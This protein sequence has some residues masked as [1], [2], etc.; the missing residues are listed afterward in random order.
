MTNYYTQ[1]DTLTTAM[2]LDYQYY[3]KSVKNSDL[4]VLA[5]TG[6]AGKLHLQAGKFLYHSGLRNASKIVIYDKSR[7]KTLG[8]F[9][10][11]FV[12]FDA[13]F[14][15]VKEEISEIPHKYLVCVGTSGGGHSAMLYAH[16]LNA[17]SAVVFSTYPY[18][19]KETIRAM[20]DPAAKMMA[21]QIELFDQLP[22]QAKKY[23]DLDKVLATW[24]G[25]TRYSMHASANHKW[26]AKRTLYMQRVPGVEIKLHPYDAHGLGGVLARSGKLRECFVQAGV[27]VGN[28]DIHPDA[29][30]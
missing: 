20:H 2:A 15:F 12:D 7:L 18:L 25:T 5:F 17:D 19:K 22:M 23:F 24:N 10:P 11:R 6:W 16:L 8:G 21:D 30:E 14:Q 9:P 4:L 3:Q 1:I 13:C 27:P 26:D 29:M 28:Y